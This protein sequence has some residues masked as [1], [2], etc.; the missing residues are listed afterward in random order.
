MF[1]S[2]PATS[3]APSGSKPTPPDTVTPGQ[4][5]TL[6][7]AGTAVLHGCKTNDDDEVK[8][9]DRVDLALCMLY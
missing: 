5:G 3:S 8:R 1:T 6:Q 4:Y 7:G 9:A 2:P